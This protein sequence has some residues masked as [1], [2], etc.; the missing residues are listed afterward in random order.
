M[1]Y[2]IKPLINFFASANIEK[3]Y[4]MVFAVKDHIFKNQGL[5]SEYNSISC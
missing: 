2:F 5:D 1:C 4:I 3:N